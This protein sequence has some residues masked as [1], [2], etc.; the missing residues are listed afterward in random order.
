MKN[1][2]L[3]KIIVEFDALQ[4]IKAIQD[5]YGDCSY[6][7]AIIDD[8]K[9]ISKDLESCVFKFVRRSANRVA[10]TLA[11]ATGSESD[12]GEWFYNHPQFISYVLA[13]DGHE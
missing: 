11:R 9:V 12:R 2:N 5:A 13:S 10:H 3:N 1:W 7:G 6:F 8:C 4:V